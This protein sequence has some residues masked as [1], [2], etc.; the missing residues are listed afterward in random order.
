MDVPEGHRKRL[1][2]VSPKDQ[3]SKASSGFLRPT[4]G[5]ASAAGMA[6][7]A[8]ARLGTRPLGHKEWS[9]RRLHA[10]H[11]HLKKVLAMQHERQ[12]AYGHRDCV[13]PGE[14]ACGVGGAGRAARRA[15]GAGGFRAGAHGSACLQRGRALQPQVRNRAAQES[16]PQSPLAARSSVSSRFPCRSC[17]VLPA[18]T[19]TPH[20]PDFR[21]SQK[22]RV[23]AAESA[24]RAPER[25]SEGGGGRGEVL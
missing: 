8:A 14:D 22:G 18:R 7:P 20:A 11:R 2:P 19:P 4:S 23:R 6:L 21:P 24:A 9:A 5:T 10:Q 17:W 16:G 12:R 13:R 1:F 15:C 25:A 3:W